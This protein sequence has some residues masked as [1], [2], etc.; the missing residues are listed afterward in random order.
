MPLRLAQSR[1]VRLGEVVAREQQRQTGQTGH[2]VSEAI[3]EC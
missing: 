1:Q 3:T 2:C